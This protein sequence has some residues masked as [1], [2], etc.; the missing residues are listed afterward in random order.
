MEIHELH[1]AMEI[2]G[3]QLH[4]LFNLKSNFME[5]LFPHDK[6]LH[7]KILP[8]NPLPLTPPE[9]SPL[10]TSVYFPIA[11]TMCKQWASS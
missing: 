7:E 10:K 2:H 5:I 6:L 1:E 9:K 3:F 11:N 4:G 8:C